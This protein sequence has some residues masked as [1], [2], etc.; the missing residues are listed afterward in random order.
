MVSDI[1][2]PLFSSTVSAAED[3]LYRNGYNMILANSHDQVEMELDIIALFKRRRIDGMIITL[4]NESE[5]RILSLLSALAALDAQRYLE[6][7]GNEGQRG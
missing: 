7:A 5:P 1:S 6:T 2:N 3:V 4:S